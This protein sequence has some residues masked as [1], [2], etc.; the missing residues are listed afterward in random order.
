MPFD[1][2]L[3]SKVT[4]WFPR[5]L[6]LSKG[7]WSGK[8]FDLLDWQRNDVIQPLFGTLKGDGMRRVRKAYIEVPKKN[9]KSPLAA[10]IGL[11]LFFA[12]N[13][14]GAEVYCAACDKEQAAIVFDTAAEMIRRNPKLMARCKIVDSTK[15]IIHQNRSLFRVLSADV[16]TKHGFNPHA[17]I[18]DELHAQPNR[19]LWDVLT[20]G[21]GAARRQPLVLAITTAGWDRTSICWEVHEQ[22]R[23][24]KEGIID[25]PSFLPV[26]YGASEEDDWKDEA[27]WKK[28]NP[29]LGSILKID[30]FRAHC[31]LAQELPQEENNF[32]RFRLNQWT[33]QETRYIPM[34]KWRGKCAEHFDPEIL[35]GRNCCVGLDLA[36]ISDLA[37]FVAVFNIGGLVH[38]LAK[39][40]VPA[41]NIEVR[42]RKDR[43]PYDLWARQGY[44]K[45]TPGNVVDYDYI[46]ADIE[47]FS[48]E[49]RIEELAYDRW[50]SAQ[51]IPH[52]EM[53][54]IKV[55][56]FGQG[57]KSFSNPTKGLLRHVL[58]GTLRHNDNPVLNWNADNVMVITDA[59]MNVQPDKQKSTE[60]I[61]GITSLIMA[62]DRLALE[63]GPSVYDTRGVISI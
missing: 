27:V 18:F 7:E 21:T 47:A 60:K 44:I 57:W 59:K 39:F 34:D 13:E 17:V 26:L 36:S 54:G 49:Y 31:K 45:P 24:I 6:Q 28:C 9:G 56:L 2:N 48:K 29:S 16:K 32:R 5:Y 20:V 30:E 37:A 4:A 38:V 15:R 1:K 10:G 62:L 53:M 40:W 19:D 12:D 25:D 14:P 50:G 63:Q 33:R 46:E 11:R 8:P 58:A 61:D 35:K 43:V 41:E 55:L 3:A 52:L 23:K 51:I 22:A 42:S